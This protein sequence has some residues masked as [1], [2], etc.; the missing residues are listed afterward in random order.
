MAPKYLELAASL[1]RPSAEQTERFVEYVAGAHSWYKHLP[2]LPPGNPFFVYLDPNAGADVS[3]SA[4]R[5]VVSERVDRSRA[6]HYTWMTTGEYRERFGHWQYAASGGPAFFSA[7]SGPIAQLAGPSRLT[8]SKLRQA[9]EDHLLARIAL[10]LAS[11]DRTPRVVD[12]AGGLV[13]VSPEVLARGHCLLTGLVHERFPA[14]LMLSR[15]GEQARE[16]LRALRTGTAPDRAPY[17]ELL[18]WFAR[19]EREPR[20][21]GLGLYRRADEM[22]AEIEAFLDAHRRAQRALLRGALDAVLGLLRA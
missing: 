15:H 1:P 13:D 21:R 10:A 8:C 18:D 17:Q 4:G 22:T 7:E 6:F 5:A 14:W 16:A 12:E 19:H 9:T 11:A 2:L 20:P 3:F